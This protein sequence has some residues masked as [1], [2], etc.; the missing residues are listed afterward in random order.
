MQIPQDSGK[1]VWYSSFFKNFPQFDVIHTVK[2]FNI[3]NDAEIGICLE[4][5]S[6]SMIQQILAI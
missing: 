4:F 2:G 5:S 6:F 1:V 3:V